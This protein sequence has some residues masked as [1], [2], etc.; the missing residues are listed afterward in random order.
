MFPNLKV[1]H[2]K[3]YLAQEAVAYARDGT[4]RYRFDIKLA[5]PTRVT[6]ELSYVPQNPHK[7]ADY[8][9][10]N[11]RGKTEIRLEKPE[12][13]L[14]PLCGQE[15][16]DE[17]MQDLYGRPVFAHRKSDNNPDISRDDTVMK[18]SKNERVKKEDKLT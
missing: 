3:D 15:F 7:L 14:V 11:V 4:R 12:T 1:D 13:S 2:Y 18:N 5:S 6:I 9:P 17:D 16:K 8:K 10:E